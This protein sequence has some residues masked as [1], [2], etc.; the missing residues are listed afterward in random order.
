[1]SPQMP[2]VFDILFYGQEVVLGGYGKSQGILPQVNGLG[3]LPFRLA[4]ANSSKPVGALRDKML[5]NH[6]DTFG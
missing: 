1:M 2:Y 5:T 6:P 4:P 3:E